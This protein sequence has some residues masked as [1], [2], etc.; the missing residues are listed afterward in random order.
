MNYY[1]LFAQHLIK[2]KE[3]KLI[4]NDGIRLQM[5]NLHSTIA[6]NSFL[7]LPYTTI[8]QNTVALTGNLGLVYLPTEDL[9]LNA[10]LSSGF[11]N[12]NIDDLARIF[13]SSSALERVVV[14]NSD[15]KAEYTYNLDL[16]ITK[17]F[18]KTVKFEITG[19]YTNFRNAIALAPF[20]I[21][22]SDSIFYNGVKCAVYANQNVKQAFSYGFNA[23]LKIDFTKQLSFFATTTYTYGRFKNDDG[24]KTPQDHI[25]PVFGKASLSYNHAKFSTEGFVLFNGWKK[26]KNYNLGGEDNQQY[27]TPDGMPSWYTLNWRNSFSINKWIQLQFA[28]E[29]ILDRNYRYFASG[30]SASGRNYILALRTMF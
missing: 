14:P 10:G 16:G 12:P 19:F 5:V 20:Q 4:V 24:T 17:I 22:G 2:L 6:D 1:G 18:N 11:R 7:N 23:N 27:A 3:E 26:I 9:R 30:F 29:N 8:E 21:N 13:E 15:I 28:I 25:P